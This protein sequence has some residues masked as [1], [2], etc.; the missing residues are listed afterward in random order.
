MQAATCR[1]TISPTTPCREVA[2]RPTKGKETPPGRHSGKPSTEPENDPQAEDQS[3]IF[4]RQCRHIVTF[5]SERR[6]VNGAHLHTFANPHGI[7][8][9]IGCYHNA[10]GC[11]YVG[12]AS[13]EFTWFSGYSWRVALCNRCLAHLG[14]R[15]FG[16]DGHTFH[17]LITSR[18][19]VGEE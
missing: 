17:G 15:F 8:F 14:W 2:L 7:I 16:A 19:I 18:L 6:M 11:G 5:P 4:C 13:T 1:Q 10:V 12:P 3:G 9:E